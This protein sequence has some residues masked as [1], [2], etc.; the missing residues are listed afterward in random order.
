MIALALCLAVGTQQAVVP[1]ERFTLAWQHTVEK[2]QW[3]EDYVVAGQWLFAA[4]A[5]IRGSGAGME[6]PP[7]SVLQDGVWHY[8]P[9]ERWLRALTLA[10]SEFGADYLLCIGGPCRPIAEWA[11]PA[12]GPVTLTPCPPSPTPRATFPAGP[13]ASRSP[14]RF[15]SIAPRRRRRQ[16]PANCADRPPAG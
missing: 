14:E 16:P 11:G 6:P 13:P 4:G 8:M 3:E 7:G 12:A 5:R 1:A 2:V 15:A 9:R 10:R